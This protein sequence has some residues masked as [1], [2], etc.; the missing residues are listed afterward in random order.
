MMQTDGNIKESI[1]SINDS[2]V[3]VPLSGIVSILGQNVVCSHSSA[4]EK[5]EKS[6]ARPVHAYLVVPATVG[7]ISLFLW[8]CFQFAALVK[9]NRYKWE[10][11]RFLCDSDT[12]QTPSLPQLF[13][14]E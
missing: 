8:H 7:V 2:L 10:R 3:E 13:A 9:A 12:G 6:E 5:Q 11:G 4:P 14:C 1:A